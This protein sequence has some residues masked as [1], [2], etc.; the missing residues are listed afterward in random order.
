MNASFGSINYAVATRAAPR[1]SALYSAGLDVVL[2]PRALLY[3]DV[4]A[5]NG[6]TTKV[7]SEWRIGASINF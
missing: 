7:V 1:D 2:G 4:S 5:Q 3:T 6:G